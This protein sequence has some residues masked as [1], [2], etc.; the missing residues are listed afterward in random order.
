MI[1]CSSFTVLS[2]CSE[3]QTERTSHS[4]NNFG[5][6]ERELLTGP[7]QCRQFSNSVAIFSP[8][9]DF[10]SEVDSLE[11]FRG[12]DLKHVLTPTTLVDVND[13][14]TAVLP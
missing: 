8:S 2:R 9:R 4:P 3:V 10:P 13:Y 5:F 12:S 7:K 11:T 6:S 1:Y 14:Q